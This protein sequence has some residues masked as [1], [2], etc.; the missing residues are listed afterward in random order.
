MAT[1]TMVQVE[2]ATTLGRPNIPKHGI[3]HSAFHV[4][5]D[6]KCVSTPN[7]LTVLHPSSSPFPSR[8]A[9]LTVPSLEY[10]ASNPPTPRSADSGSYKVASNSV[11]GQAAAK[12]E[13]Q[14]PETPPNVDTT[15]STSA[16]RHT[17]SMPRNGTAN[18]SLNLAES[19]SLAEPP[20]AWD[21]DIEHEDRQKERKADSAMR[22]TTPFE[23]DRR[24]LKDVV[25]EKM[26]IEVGRIKFLSAGEC[27]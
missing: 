3:G 5:F 25:R 15:A 4:V 11:R 22:D 13:L 21:W 1:Q 6:Y 16:T 9:L 10:S 7:Y 12:G 17:S 27:C 19:L 2:T 24:L 18:F 8:I 26:G 14:Q 23:V 20:L